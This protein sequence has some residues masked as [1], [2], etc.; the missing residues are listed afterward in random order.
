V[1]SIKVLLSKRAVF[2]VKALQFKQA[3]LLIST[4][5]SIMSTYSMVAVLLIKAARLIEAL[6]SI[7]AVLLT[8]EV[9][10]IEADPSVEATSSI[11][12]TAG[13]PMLAANMMKC[14]VGSS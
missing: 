8:E 6:P 9:F 12:M 11:N 1:P 14:Y 3:A 7:E 5:S 13:L 10:L 2:L 4:G